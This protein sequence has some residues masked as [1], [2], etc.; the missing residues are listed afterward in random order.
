MQPPGTGTHTRRPVL[1]GLSVAIMLV[2]LVLAVSATVLDGGQQPLL[3][4]AD[5]D[6]PPGRAAS[7][8]DDTFRALVADTLVAWHVP[9]VAVAVLDGDETWMEVSSPCS[10]RGPLPFSMTAPDKQGFGLAALPDT[11]VTPHTLFYTASTT[12]AFVA[13]ALALMVDS[14]NYSVAPRDDRQRAP[15]PLAWTTPLADMLP[16][17]FVLAGDACATRRLV[18]DDALSHRTGLPAHD[19]ARARRYGLAPESARRNASVRDVTRSLRH[20]PLGTAPPR[21][22][23]R[24]C[25]LMFLVLSHAVET[26][27]GGQWLGDVL[28]AWLWAPLGMRETFL[29]L[30]DARAAP[31]PAFLAQGYYYSAADGSYTGVPHMPL[32]EVSGAGGV[33]SSVHDYARWL[34]C[35][36]DGPAFGGDTAAC[37]G[38]P[39]AAAALDAVLAPK[40]FLAHTAAS[41][42]PYDAPMAY[43]SAWMTTSYKGRR[44]WGHSGGSKYVCRPALFSVRLLT[45]QCLWRP[46]LLLP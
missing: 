31:A 27:T 43:A 32:E 11:P 1:V 42:A 10:Q 19:L 17:D 44:F 45:P 23:W 21:T 16:D 12:K 24:Y 34:R 8:F 18:L 40:I 9:G 5:A 13:A 30:D 2:A 46:G 35:W 15:E 20:L 7:P 6:K 33:I 37:G 26:L 36:I 25:N 38:I 39:L 29:S 14:G 3:D 41:P 22:A 28:R 4:G